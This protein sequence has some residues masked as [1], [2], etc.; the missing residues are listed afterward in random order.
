MKPPPMN[1]SELIPLIVVLVVA[2]IVWGVI[3][4]QAHRWGY[5]GARSERR[6]PPRRDRRR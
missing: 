2:P 4:E 6:D 1:W 5:P 3:R